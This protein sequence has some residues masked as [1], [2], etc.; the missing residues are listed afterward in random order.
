MLIPGTKLLR[1][2][3]LNEYSK[4]HIDGYFLTMC[5]ITGLK[6]MKSFHVAVPEVGMMGIFLKFLIIV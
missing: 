5:I 4:F 1:K 2:D 3:S 6:N